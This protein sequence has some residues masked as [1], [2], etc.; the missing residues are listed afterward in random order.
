[1]KVW[2]CD[3][4]VDW[5]DPLEE[6]DDSTMAKVAVAGT[7]IAPALCCPG[8]RMACFTLDLAIVVESGTFGGGVSFCFFDLSS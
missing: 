6:P 5:A 2:Q 7:L 4:I 8:A 3:I 1:M